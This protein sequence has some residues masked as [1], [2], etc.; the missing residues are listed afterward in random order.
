[1]KTN[2]LIGAISGNYSVKDIENWVKTSD[3]ED[4]DRVL[5]LYNG[6]ETSPLVPYLAENNVDVYIASYN[7]F[8]GTQYD[9]LTDTGKV[10]AESSYNLVHNIR[11][12]HIANFL[13]DT[14]YEKVF[15][16]DVKDV[17]F[18]Q[19]P[20]P[21]VP[22]QGIIATGEVIKYR[23]HA[24]NLEHLHATIGMIG[25]DLF[26]EEVLN[27][28]VFGGGREDVKTIC[29]DIYLIACG[30][31]K[32]ADQTAFNYL[33]RNAYR[34]KTIFTS[35]DDKFAVHLHVIK[36]GAVKFDL[37]NVK[38]YTVIHQYDRFGDEIFN[39]YTLP[40]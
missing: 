19:S 3:F 22:K 16:T 33:T 29:N 28:G 25:V 6:D 7:F 38:D 31:F 5:Y 27:V 30:K 32:V 2:L 39:Y 20:F 36:E 40:Q 10:T 17:M 9:F 35:L 12:L 11:F 26:D 23:Q 14:T 4:T 37:N 34:H 24:W 15:I 1:M 21:R 13:R 18:T 8:T